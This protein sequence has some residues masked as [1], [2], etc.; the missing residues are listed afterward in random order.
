LK[1]LHP[2]IS[3]YP[4]GSDHTKLAAAWLID[5]CGYKGKRVGNTGSYKN[6]A[7]VIVNHGDATGQEIW[8]YALEV[9][10]AV[11]EKFGV[12]IEPEVNVW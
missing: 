2:N 12:V 7:L 4:N 10:S 3:A 6:Q 11:L 8:D 5:Q 1:Y 9:K